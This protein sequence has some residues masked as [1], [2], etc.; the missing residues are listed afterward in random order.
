MIAAEARVQ[1]LEEGLRD[2]LSEFEKMHEDFYECAQKLVQAE[3][4]IEELQKN[5]DAL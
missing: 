1:E 3:A 2:S 5:N 4:K